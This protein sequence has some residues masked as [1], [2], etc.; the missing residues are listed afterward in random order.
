MNRY[1]IVA[2]VVLSVIHLAAAFFNS[3]GWQIF[4]KP[5]LVP[6]LI[7]YY[8]FARSNRPLSLAFVLAL[9]FCWVGDVLLLFDAYFLPGLLAFL[10]GHLLYIVT[11][12]HH[13]NASSADTL[14]ALQRLRMALPVI[15]FASGIV[16]VLYP[17]LGNLQVPV[18]LY[19]G[20][21]GYMV[22]QAL[23]RYG[24]TPVTSFVLV[25]AG[26]VLFMLSDSILAFNKFV[27][28]VAHGN[29]WIMLT[30]AV[31]QFLLVTG[32]LRHEFVTD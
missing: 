20:V 29:F 15:L 18:M 23:F 13:C 30:Y 32:I 9:F 6:A 25:F 11:W 5:L 24:R 19:A 4:S 2:F 8:V 28:P 31:A 7:G 21:L 17:R 14:T 26:S 12:R 10:V 3:A 22:L 1:F 27:Q 16:V